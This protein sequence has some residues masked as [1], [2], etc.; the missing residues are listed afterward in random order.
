[1]LRAL[2][3]VRQQHRLADARVATY[4]ECLALA[5]ADVPHQRVE[6]RTLAAPAEHPLREGTGQLSGFVAVLGC[7]MGFSEA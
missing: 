6:R 2:G 4:H 7:S 1:M 5:R 3:H